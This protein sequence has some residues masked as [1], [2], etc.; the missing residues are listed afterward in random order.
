MAVP[1]IVR[2]PPIAAAAENVLLPEPDNTRLLNVVADAAKV[3]AAPPK[4]TIPVP[5]VKFA[6]VPFHAVMLVLFS[7]SVL[8]PPFNI[9]TVSDT[10]PANVC[11]NPLP[12]FSVPTVPAAGFKE[13]A[14]IC[15]SDE[16]ET[17]HDIWVVPEPGLLLPEKLPGELENLGV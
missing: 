15:Q 6:P 14:A 5:A 11:V 7:F 17:D 3:W 12:K 1:L 2:F 10:S 8:D 9:P 16:D 4:F 13:T